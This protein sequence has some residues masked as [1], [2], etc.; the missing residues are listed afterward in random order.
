MIDRLQMGVSAI[1]QYTNYEC[2]YTL[3]ISA[4]KVFNS[5]KKI[6]IGVAHGMDRASAIFMKIYEHFSCKCYM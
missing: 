4:F 2:F 1:L 5:A 3:M 6:E